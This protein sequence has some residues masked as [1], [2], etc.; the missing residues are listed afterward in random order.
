MRNV[1]QFHS[2]RKSYDLE[3]E[4]KPGRD[5]LLTRFRGDSA[6]EI[7]VTFKHEI[8]ISFVTS[9]LDVTFNTSQTKYFGNEKTDYQEN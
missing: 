9:S 5:H 2:E 4:R 7:S 6:V 3:T 8:K 1:G